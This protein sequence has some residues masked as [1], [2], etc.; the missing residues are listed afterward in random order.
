MVNTIKSLSSVIMIVFFA[1][2]G[3]SLHIHD[4]IEIWQLVIIIFL[5]RA[6]LVW[7][8]E[9]VAHQIAGSPQVLKTY[10]FTPFISQAGLSIGLSMI[11]YER[12]PD[13][14]PKLATLAIS[15]V[16]LNEIFGPILFKWGLNRV[17]KLK[18]PEETDSVT[19]NASTS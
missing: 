7:A 19:A 1:T 8:S 15:V 4:L 12:L 3:A 9:R 2:A 14:G 13:I 5:A 18:N 10:G 6:I 16:T 17:E 11:L